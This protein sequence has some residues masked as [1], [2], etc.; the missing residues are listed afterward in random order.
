MYT[1]YGVG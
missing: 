1:K